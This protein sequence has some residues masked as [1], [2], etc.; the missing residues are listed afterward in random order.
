MRWVTKTL[1]I[2]APAPASLCQILEPIVD[3]KAT[4]LPS[5][6]LELYLLR[7]Q[8]LKSAFMFFHWSSSSVFL[9]LQ[10]PSL[11]TGWCCSPQSCSR[12]GGPVEVSQYFSNSR[13]PH[14]SSTHTRACMR[15]HFRCHSSQVF[16]KCTV[17]F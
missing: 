14:N 4:I 5:P 9:G 16:I 1:H 15:E 10:M 7:C 8:T 13:H 17:P 6:V 12:R 11:T 2:S 3:H